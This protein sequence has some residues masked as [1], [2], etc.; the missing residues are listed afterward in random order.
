MN[1]Y[2]LRYSAWQVAREESAAKSFELQPEKD[3]Q[4]KVLAGLQY[5]VVQGLFV[6]FRF[7]QS[8]NQASNQ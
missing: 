8:V 6:W 3:L 2:D 1:I 5:R 4:V 7:S